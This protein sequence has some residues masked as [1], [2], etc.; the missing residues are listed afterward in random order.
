MAKSRTQVTKH[1]R[2]LVFERDKFTC[3]YCGAKSPDVL[4]EI[5][6]LIPY[7]KGGGNDIDNLVTACEACNNGKSDSVLP[8]DLIK[9]I[10]SRRVKK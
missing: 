2:F 7:S 8:D 9:Q 5:D 6:H 1:R 3:Q 10:K 4:L